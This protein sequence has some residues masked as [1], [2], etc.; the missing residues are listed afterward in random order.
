MRRSK[1]GWLGSN[2]MGDETDSAQQGLQ[3]LGRGES[4][5]RLFPLVYSE[6]RALAQ[7]WFSRASLTGTLQPT[8]VV[9]E[10][11]VRLVAQTGCRWQD[12]MHFRAIAAKAMRQILIDH[13]RRSR[14]LKRGGKHHRVTLDEAVSTT[15]KSQVVDMLDLDEAL[16]EL[17][18]LNERQGKI[19]QLRFLAGSTVAEIAKLV[20]VSERTVRLEWKMARAWLL[21][22]LDTKE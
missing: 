11:Y 3:E 12:C 5:E 6:L 18:A 9:H 16:T 20:G 4:A 22:R 8:A 7:S 2:V 10:A 15:S 17:S 13:A 19:A 1:N 14:A 21:C